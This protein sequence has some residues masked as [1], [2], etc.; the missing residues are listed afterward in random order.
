MNRAFFNLTSAWISIFAVAITL[1]QAPTIVG[2]TQP[3]IRPLDGSRVLAGEGRVPDCVLDCFLH[4]CKQPSPQ[5]VVFCMKG[6][7]RVPAARW[8]NRGA[9]S[10]TLIDSIPDDAETLVRTLLTAKGVWF[11]S[12]V[13]ELPSGSLLPALLRNVSER[14]GVIGG[15]GTGAVA[16]TEIG[17]SEKAT[18]QSKRKLVVGL[19]PDSKIGFTSTDGQPNPSELSNGCINWTIPNSTALVIH[20]GRKVSA[21]GM[22]NLTATIKRMGQWPQRVARLNAIDAFDQGDVPAYDLD[23]MAWRRS[24]QQQREP[25]FPAKKMPTPTLSKGTLLLHGGSGVDDATFERFIET[26]GGRD[27]KFVC[28]PSASSFDDGEELNSYSARRLREFGCSNVSILHTA[29]PRVAE[30]DSRFLAPLKVANGVW[31]DGGRTFRFMDCY[32]GTQVQRLLRQVLERD[33]VVGGSSAGCQVAGDFLV[34]GNPRTNNDMVFEGYTKG[35]AL[36]EGVVLDAHF[37]QRGRDEPFT[38]LMNDYPQLLGIGVDERTAIVI[39]QNTAE[40]VGQNSVSF[41]D[42]R[43][44]GSRESIAL[45]A[46]ESYNLKTRQRVK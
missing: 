25:I 14:G 1:F 27:A 32:Q 46:G 3:F 5:I 45:Q 29:D 37:L 17:E 8:K 10:V 20:G 42:W 22:K 41:Y 12:Q 18:S 38:E 19:L 31:I 11:E 23:L 43:P 2:Q 4:L 9:G 24:V 34:R 36:I 40:V 7:P 26:A 33:G 13:G 21:I 6:E 28:I 16:V 39:H 15:V 35:L 30:Q 44:A